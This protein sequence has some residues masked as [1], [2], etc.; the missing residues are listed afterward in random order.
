MPKLQDLIY[1]FEEGGGKVWLRVGASVLFLLLIILSYNWFCFRNMA[2]QEA[3]D[4]AQ[5]GRNIAEG[6][7]FTTL[8]VRPFSMRLLENRAARNPDLT[9]PWESADP[10]RLQGMH[11][12]LANAPVYPLILAGLMKLLPFDYQVDLTHRFW[13][14]SGG[15][16][17][18]DSE[19]PSQARRF[20]RYQP[21][22]MISGFN[23]LVFLVVATLSFF[24]CRRL[25]DGRTAVFSTV[26]LLGTDLLWRFAV[27]G[28]ATIVLVLIFSCMVWCL[29]RLDETSSLSNEQ[30]SSEAS[31]NAGPAVNQASFACQ[32]NKGSA[33]VWAALIG[34]L[35]GLGALTR[36][37][38]GWLIVP[39]LVFIALFTGRNRLR[40]CLVAFVAFTM[41][42]TPWIIRTALVS[43]APFGTATYAIVENSALFPADTL[44]RSLDPNLA[45]PGLIFVKLTW[46]KLLSNGSRIIQNDLPRL[47]GTWAGSFFVVGLLMQLAERRTRRLGYFLGFCLAVLAVVQALGQ[48]H[49]SAESPDVNSE[50]LLI[51]LVPIIWMYGTNFFYRLLGR[52]DIPLPQVR[53]LI[54]GGF[55]ALTCL[56]MILA[57][58]AAN[59]SPVVYPPYYPPSI[60]TAAGFV[61]PDELMMSD[62]PWAVAWYGHSQCVWLTQSKRDF[63]TI[64]DH[65]KPIRALYLT[66]ATG[67]GVFESLDQWI[68]AGDEGWGDFIMSCLLRKEQGKPGPPP[69]FPLEFWQKGRPLDF[70]LTSREK[71]LMDAATR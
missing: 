21:D 5:L 33:L 45:L 15:R 40:L 38:F 52:L 16:A 25:F 7:G 30:D 35:V 58:L 53:P 42:F 8:F 43:G 28:L 39:V 47:G 60:Q 23:Q 46:S 54:T 49:L 11:P 12:D 55:A 27:S 10:A 20:R 71:P 18:A 31:P 4:Y 26:M 44:Q 29:V 59:R 3:M 36:Y 51:L 2:T 41:I 22:F 9:A 70:L 68:R 48:T 67:E 64:N 66:H 56:P 32:V 62:I 69:D 14:S 34:V 24:L 1:W 63:F 37:S 57:L 17:V 19:E 6:K 65:Q 50:N 61:K 13:S